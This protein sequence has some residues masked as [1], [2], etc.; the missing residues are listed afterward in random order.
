M[1]QAKTDKK[2]QVTVKEIPVRYNSEDFEPGQKIEIEEKH[3][4]KNL[5]SK[6]E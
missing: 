2:I 5:F 6:E 4:D 1:A 3:F